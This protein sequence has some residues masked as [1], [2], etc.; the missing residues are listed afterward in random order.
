MTTR[1]APRTALIVHAH[2][3]PLSFATAQMREAERALASRGVEVTVVDLHEAGWDPV[4]SRARFPAASGHFK[5][6]AEQMAAVRDGLVEPAVARQLDA[7]LAAD[8]LVLSFPLWW[9]SVPAILKGWLD[10]V[11]VMGAVFGGDHGLFDE[12]A[13][14]GRRAVLLMTTGG[15]PESFGAGSRF[16]DLEALLFPLHHGTLRFVGYDVLEPVVTHGPARLDDSAR[17][18]ALREVHAAFDSIAARRVLQLTT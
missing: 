16:G 7:L 13:L 8:L 4:L 6:Q 10:R 9:F 1:D 18:T 2:P 17:D 3:E 12:A 11:L 5:P 14:A 15:S